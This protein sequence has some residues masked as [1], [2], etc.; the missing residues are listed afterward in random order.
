MLLEPKQQWGQRLS[1][2]V[3]RRAPRPPLRGEAQRGTRAKQQ[4]SW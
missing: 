2:G 1:L 4:Q 3:T